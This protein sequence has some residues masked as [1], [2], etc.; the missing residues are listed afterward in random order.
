MESH[1]EVEVEQVDVDISTAARAVMEM[2]DI[3]D[4]KNYVSCNEETEDL[5]LDDSQEDDVRIDPREFIPI[6]STEFERICPIIIDGDTLERQI[7]DYFLLVLSDFR[8]CDITHLQNLYSQVEQKF[9]FE[10]I[11]WHIPLC[12][13]VCL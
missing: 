2:L 13:L 5:G 3:S 9:C 11:S 4:D 1:P 12:N 10:A 6:P 8:R 7:K